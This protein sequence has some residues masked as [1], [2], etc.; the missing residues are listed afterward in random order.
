SAEAEAAAFERGEAVLEV[1]VELRRADPHLKA[2][3]DRSH[4]EEARIAGSAAN[5][6]SVEESAVNAKAN[7]VVVPPVPANRKQL[8]RKPVGQ[9]LC[10]RAFFGDPF[11]SFSLSEEGGRRPDEGASTPSG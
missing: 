7:A 6:V 3:I 11:G 8:S 4:P 5:E 9:A 1:E 2:M 10:Q